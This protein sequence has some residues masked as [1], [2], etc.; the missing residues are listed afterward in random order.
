MLRKQIGVFVDAQI[1]DGYRELCRREKLRPFQPIEEF[2]KLI[3][4]NGSTLKV[5]SMTR[6]MARVE[7][8]AFEAYARVLLNWY[9][10]GRRWIHVT[11][12]I[13][14]P[15]EQMLL[16][17]LKDVADPR[18]RG[19]IQETLIV[20]AHERSSHKNRKGSIANN[21]ATQE[22]PPMEIA[23]SATSERIQE[24]K[25]RIT[26]RT[27]NPEKAKRMLEKIHEIREKLKSDEKERNRKHR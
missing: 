25:K 20:T 8:A 5:L 10:T 19:E 24:I 27:M 13:E 7:P 4:R 9:K 17:S 2:L 14:A 15:V 1:W 26:G 23:A 12:E 21:I 3:I 18:L 22:E 11:D 6:S 16:Q